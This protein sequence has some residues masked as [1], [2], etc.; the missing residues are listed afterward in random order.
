MVRRKKGGVMSLI[1]DLERDVIKYLDSNYGLEPDE[2]NDDS[3]LE[4]L[5]VDSLGV[6]GIA[7]IADRKYGLPLLDDERILEVRSLG[8]FKA[9]LVVISAEVAGQPVKTS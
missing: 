9:L 8:E 1:S 5:G 4:S 7:D 2:I 3:T 6:L